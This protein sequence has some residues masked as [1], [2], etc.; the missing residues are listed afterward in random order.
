VAG[1][2]P[3]RARGFQ[4]QDGA[5][6]AREVG[7]GA[8]SGSSCWKG[9]TADRKHDRAEYLIHVWLMVELM[10]LGFGVFHFHHHDQ[11]SDQGDS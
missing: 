6:N 2:R 10:M 9:T 8:A 5:G 1:G 4:F 11:S 3:G 7:G